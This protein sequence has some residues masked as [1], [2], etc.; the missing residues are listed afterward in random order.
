MFKVY[1]QPFP[2]TDRYVYLGHTFYGCFPEWAPGIRVLKPTKRLEHGRTPAVHRKKPAIYALHIEAAARKGNSAIV[3]FMGLT[4]VTALFSPETLVQKY[5]GLALPAITYG[6]SAFH[7]S[8]YTPGPENIVRGVPAH[9]NGT[10]PA[11]CRC[12][13]GQTDRTPILSP[14]AGIG[15][16]FPYCTRLR[17]H[18]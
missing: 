1:D 12:E 6:M 5:R 9:R 14:H 15:A 7:D 2:Y 10:I 18:V 13:Q 3:Q 11:T 16:T 4:T 17:C 8:I